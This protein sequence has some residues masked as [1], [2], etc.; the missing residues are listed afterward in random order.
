MALESFN[1]DIPDEEAENITVQQA[2]SFIENNAEAVT[3]VPCVVVLS[4]LA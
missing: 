3:A 2:I 1:I 4:S